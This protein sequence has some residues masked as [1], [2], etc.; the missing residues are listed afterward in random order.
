MRLAQCTWLWGHGVMQGRGARTWCKAGFC[1]F[2]VW[3][4]RLVFQF[5]SPLH[6]AAPACN[7]VKTT[8]TISYYSSRTGPV[9]AQTYRTAETTRFEQIGSTRERISLP[10][11]VLQVQGD[12]YRRVRPSGDLKETQ[13]SCAAGD[14]AFPPFQ[15]E[16]QA[17]RSLT[18]AAGRVTQ[19]TI[20]SPTPPHITS[21]NLSARASRFPIKIRFQSLLKCAHLYLKVILNIRVQETLSFWLVAHL[22]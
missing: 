10:T 20:G 13:S 1:R 15:L 12:S 3:F 18:K 4:F 16:A 19:S 2:P 7:P 17:G 8:T 14:S 21:P 5:G 22:V 6:L 9:K 11:A